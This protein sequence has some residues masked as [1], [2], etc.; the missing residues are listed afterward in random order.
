MKKKEK[1]MRDDKTNQRITEYEKKELELAFIWWGQQQNF[2][3]QYLQS[4]A[5]KESESHLNNFFLAIAETLKDVKDES[6]NPKYERQ[7]VAEMFEN[8]LDESFGR[9]DL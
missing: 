2:I 1:K 7:D 4:I 9:E 6:G 8:G 3:D 5:E